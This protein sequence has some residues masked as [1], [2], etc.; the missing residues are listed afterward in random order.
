MDAARVR[1]IREDMERA[2]ARR[3]QPH[4]I[5]SFFLEALRHLGGTVHERE[6]KRYE[7]THVPSVIR[8]R[9][10]LIGVGDSVL[11]RYERITFEKD[12][13]S[14][15]GSPL[16]A[17]VC[18]GHPLLDATSDLVRERYRDLLK[19]GAVLVDRRSAGED[20]R[21]L[22]YLEHS[23][24]DARADAS[25]T[26]RVVSR[27]MQFVE[28]DAAGRVKNAGYAPYLDYEPVKEQ[29]R[30][31]L[32]EVLQAAWLAEGLESRVLEY[33]V[34]ELVP[35]HFEEIRRRKEDL[36]AK[37]LAAVKDRLT[38]EIN[39]W[40]H[41]A[42]E[43]KAQ[44]LAGRVNARIN[45]GK[46][47]QRADELQARLQKRMEELEQE[48]R[49]SPLPPVVI[50]GALVVP[51]RLLARLKGEQ[52]HR[53]EASAEERQRVAH[54]A[55]DAVMEAERLLGF[56]PRDVSSENCGYDVESRVPGTGKL[57]FLEVKG[58]T[59][60][61][62]TV[63]VTK[64]EILTALN[65]PEDFILAL[66]EVDGDHNVARYVRRPFRREPDFGVTSVNYHLRELLAK[67][68]PPQ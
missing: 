10:R 4:F 63:T 43:L 5:E 7:V 47:R 29:D 55:M 64:N 49:L 57:R 50:G 11:A 62:D 26:R 67:A 23:I 31:L 65:K 19:R 15:H 12:L 59:L 18:P 54:L 42:E 3:L 20:L 2:E 16:A 14:V 28:V 41:R 66:V 6:T 34:S 35:R 22:V 39:Y 58:R 8:N 37:T 32:S 51:G 52:P 56:E 9:D 61:A 53:Q 40:D 36:I 21:A 48:R 46:A 27:Q 60:G 13:I 17:F 33:A 44:E 38:K 30:E 25:G 24:Q 45:S 68:D 1:Q